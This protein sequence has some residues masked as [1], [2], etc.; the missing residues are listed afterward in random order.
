MK[1]SDRNSNYLKQNKKTY[2]LCIQASEMQVQLQ[3][4]LDPWGR[5]LSELTLCYLS[6]CFCLSHDSLFPYDSQ[7]GRRQ[8]Q[9]HNFTMSRTIYKFPISPCRKILGLWLD[10]TKSHIQQKYIF[11]VG[12]KHSPL[13]QREKTE[14]CH[15]KFKM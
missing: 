2:Y 15:I 11:R 14:N 9:G 5:M 7:C 12:E 13:P 4:C 1:A 10:R 6:V 8:L 3:G